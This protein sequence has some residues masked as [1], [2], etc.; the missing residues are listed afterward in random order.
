MNVII[1]VVLAYMLGFN[2]S[3]TLA[4]KLKGKLQIT[5]LK[6]ECVWILHP[7][8]S[9]FGFYTLKFESVWIVHL[10]VSKFGI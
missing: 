2:V 8:V 1:E 5:P 6:F 7:E 4:P 10:D 3:F 9:E